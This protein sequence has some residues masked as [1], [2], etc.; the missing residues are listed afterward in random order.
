M[1]KL[2]RILLPMLSLVG[3]LVSGCESQEERL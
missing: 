3:L 2:T 1:R